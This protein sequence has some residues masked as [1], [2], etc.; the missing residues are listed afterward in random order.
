MESEPRYPYVAVDVTDD[1][2]DAASG[3]LFELGA[4]GLEQRD[5]T[6]LV[7]GV[8]AR[9]TLVASFED[10][11]SAQAAVDDL[12]AEWSPRIEEVVG[13]G[14]RDEW[15]KHFEPFRVCEGVVVRPPWREYVAGKGEHVIELEPGRAFGTGLHETTS[16]VAEVLAAHAAQFQGKT[17]LDVGTGSGI[18]SF[19]AIALGA[20]GAL[21]IDVDP[22]AVQVTR[23]NA[24][25]NGLS[26]RVEASLRPVEDV[27]VSYPVVLANIEA[28]TL[29]DIAQ[30]LMP[31]VE[32]GGLLVLSG[33]LAPHVAPSQRDDVAR[34]YRAMRLE[35]VKTKGEWIAMVFVA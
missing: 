5:A 21:A 11:A 30:A 12:P 16:L 31:R 7:R 10:H 8:A 23:E 20:K 6:T 35:D 3:K 33:I 27:H 26:S 18:L 28:R 17:V 2:A 13:D 1:D 14:W 4:Q 15:K 22:D 25:R 19:V 32:P 29:V 9:V 24:A 34:A